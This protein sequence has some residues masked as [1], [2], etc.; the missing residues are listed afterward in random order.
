MGSDGWLW[1]GIDSFVMRYLAGSSGALRFLCKRK[2]GQG[3]ARGSVWFQWLQSCRA[4]VKV[5]SLAQ[6]TA[7]DVPDAGFDNGEAEKWGPTA[8]HEVK[9]PT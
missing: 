7:E 1:I 6:Q 9:L 4:A 5:E 8:C 3:A 2:G